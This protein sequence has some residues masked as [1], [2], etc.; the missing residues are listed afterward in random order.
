MPQIKLI[1]EP[2]Y[3]YD[4]IY[5]FYLKFNFKLCA[6]AI[7][8]YNKQLDTVRYFDEI[9]KRFSDIPDDLF[10]FFHA[11]E[12]GRCF[13]AANY[14]TPYKDLFSTTYT[15]QFLQ[16][17]LSDKNQL[18]RNLIHFYFYDLDEDEIERCAASQQHLFSHIKQS[19]YSSEEK[20]KLYEFFIH[21]DPYIQLLQYELMTKEFT[22]SKYYEN[23]YQKIWDIYNQTTFE[24]LSEQIKD[25]STLNFIKEE[26]QS[27]YVSYCL[28]NMYCIDIVLIPEG[29]F[30][31]LGRDY[32]TSVALNKAPKSS[33][34]LQE[35]GHACS[36]ESRVKI[37]QFLLEREEI[38]CKDLEK[39]F[40][41]SGSTAYHHITMML[42]I[43]LLKS[44]NNRK[45]ILYSLNRQYFD[46]IIEVLNKFS[47]KKKG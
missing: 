13:L 45:T 23:N 16:N 15:F 14:F 17:Q 21:P 36:E 6:E 9:L 18:I 29:V 47:T 37:L 44:R 41:F 43:G 22:L 4:L 27:I 5:I 1:K 28:L 8:V 24:I 38:T 31:I 40:S 11:L 39:E 20:S 3:I 34:N 46:G 12:N 33:F 26:N 32:L 7:D 30:T 19:E 35:F 25:I 42:K 10:V 2:G